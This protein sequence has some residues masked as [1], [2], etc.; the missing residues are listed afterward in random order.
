MIRS[1]IDVSRWQGTI[2]W[3]K[4]KSA[5]VEFA[6]LRAGYGNSLAYPYQIDITFEYNYKSCKAVGIPVGIYWYSY[7]TNEAMAIQEA[8][9]CI[10]VL[11]GKQLE[12]PVFYDVEEMSIF[13]TGKTDQIIKAFADEMI[14]AGYVV[15]VYIYRSAAQGYLNDY[16]RNTYEMAIAEYGPRLNYNGPYGVWQNSSTIRIDGINGNVDHD[17]CYKDYP[18]IIKQQG[19][20]GYSATPTPTPTPTPKPTPTPVKPTIKKTNEQLADEVIAGKWS[21]GDERRKLLTEA[22]Y[23][24]D[25]VQAIV[26]VKMANIN[27]PKPAA[28]KKTVEELARE[29]IAGKWSA[30]DERRRLLTKEGYNYTLVQNKVNELMGQVKPA[31]KS[32]MEIAK[33]VVR[34]NWGAGYERKQRLI[35][36]GYDYNTIQRL[37]EQIMRG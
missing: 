19:K 10:A 7:A 22:G 32:N 16:T 26:N 28:P 4:V 5:G 12:Y 13:R 9:S 30:G 35:A 11:K 18:T 17:Y 15:G 27:K 36:A 31:K 34:G 2:N 8:K 1:G 24:Y 37:V 25:A 29:V 23:N 20:N 14:K 3:Q 6:L 33:E 21:S